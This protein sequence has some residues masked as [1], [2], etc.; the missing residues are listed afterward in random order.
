L[1]APFRDARRDMDQRL[2]WDEVKEPSSTKEMDMTRKDL[3]FVLS[4]PPEIL[5][6]AL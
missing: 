3:F 5:K 1:G 4:P 6:L 2:D